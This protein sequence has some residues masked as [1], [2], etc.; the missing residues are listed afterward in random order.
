MI[1]DLFVFGH[2][3]L[4]ENANCGDKHDILYNNQ[5]NARPLIGQSAMA[6]CASELMEISRV[7][8]IILYIKKGIDHNFYG[9]EA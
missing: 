9:L 2:R 4:L 3:S 7:F 6:Y 1:D 8:T 5:M